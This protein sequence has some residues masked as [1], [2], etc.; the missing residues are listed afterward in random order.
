MNPKILSLG[1]ALPG[2]P[3]TQE[4]VFKAFGYPRHFWRLFREA[5][6]ETRHF[7]LNESNFKG[8]DW[9]GLCEE[10]ERGATELSRQAVLNCMD[11]RTLDDIGCIV[12][13]SCTGYACPSVAHRLGLPFPKN[14]FYTAVLGQGCEG[15]GFPGLKRAY[16]FC[17]STGKPA[18]VIGCELSSCTF[19]P[20]PDGKAD[21]ENHYELLRG[22]TIFADAAAAALVGFDDDPRHPEIVDMEAHVEP[23]YL[24]YL[25]YVWR[26]GRLRLLLAPE[27]PEL[28]PKVVTPALANLLARNNLSVKDIDWWVIHAAGAPVIDNIRDA[29]GLSE[30]QM[31]L[32]RETLRRFGNCSSVTVG[33]SAKLLMQEYGP[34]PGDRVV[35]ASVG[36]GMM[37][38]VSLMRFPVGG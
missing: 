24:S 14:A 29:I 9:Q 23:E 3:Y 30:E 19:F 37:G 26:E 33:L 4:E 15:A 8:L 7:W 38:G 22:A 27:V 35:S 12:F 25:G 1:Y 6:V 18:L 31:A 5:G 17:V 36:P 2:K 10:Y 11:G 13:A 32:S 34:E 28:A 16:D 20:E 21:P